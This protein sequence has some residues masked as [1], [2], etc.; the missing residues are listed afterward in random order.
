M[1]E[2]AHEQEQDHENELEVY[3]NIDP[4]LMQNNHLQHPD[5][6][7]V[8][9]PEPSRHFGAILDA[10]GVAATEPLPA[11]AISPQSTSDVALVSMFES[12][13]WSTSRQLQVGIRLTNRVKI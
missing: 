12:P 7:P 4:F 5:L 13:E 1:D 10:I 2:H 9:Q 3:H 6:H 11:H 8:H